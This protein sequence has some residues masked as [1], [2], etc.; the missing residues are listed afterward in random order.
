MCAC[1]FVCVVC[2]CAFVCVCVCVRKCVCLFVMLQSCVNMHIYTLY[3]NIYYVSICVQMHSKG[4]KVTTVCP[5]SVKTEMCK[6]SFVGTTT[7][8]DDRDVTR[9]VSLSRIGAQSPERY[10]TTIT[11][12]GF[13]WYIDSR[14]F[15]NIGCMFRNTAPFICR[16]AE[17]ILIAAA[18][19]MEEVWVGAF[20]IMHALYLGWYVPALYTPIRK[21]LAALVDNAM[22]D[23][24]ESVRAQSLTQLS[25]SSK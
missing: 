16:C 14:L 12:L 23:T 1:A 21:R 2:A 22:A 13:F 10:Y 3:H 15:S 11:V 6:K 24:E 5:S 8:E 9:L 18:N 19:G 7:Q 17:L 25:L 20:P 4:I